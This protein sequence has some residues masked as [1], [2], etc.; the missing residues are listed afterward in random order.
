MRAAPKVMPPMLSCWPTTSEADVGSMVVEAQPSHQYSPTFCCHATDGSRGAI[1]QNGVWHGSEDE[2]KV[3]NWIPPC[4][5]NGTHWHSLM[6]AEYLWRPN[7]GCEHSKAVG[8]TF[9]QWQKWHERQAMFQTATL[10]GHTTKWGAFQSA[11]PHA[12][13][14]SNQGTPYGAEY[15][16]HCIR[17]DGML[18]YCKVCTRW[19][20]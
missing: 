19:V 2:A 8:G 18:E 5:K 15:Q 1:W 3:W 13:V 12:S 17:N 10:S 6:L 16:L 7:S 14:D 20:P 4:R 11:C 9:Q